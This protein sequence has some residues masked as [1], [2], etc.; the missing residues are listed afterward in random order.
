MD[1]SEFSEKQKTLIHWW[2]RDGTSSCDG[3]IADGAIRSG[4]TISMICGFLLWSQSMFHDR[5]FIIAGVTIT[6]VTRNVVLPMFEILNDWRWPFSQNKQLG[7]VKIGSNYYWVLSGGSDYAQDRMQGMTAAGAFADE[8]ALMSKKFL[9]QMIGRCSVEGSKVWFNCNPEN[10]TAFFKTD[11]IDVRDDKNLLYV[12]FLMDDNPSLSEETKARY[13]RMFHGVFRERYILGLWTKA[14]GLIYPEYEASFEEP[15][16]YTATQWAISCDYGTQNPFCALKWCKDKLGIW[17][18]VDEYYY[19][20]RAEGHQ[21]TDEDYANEMETFC[22]G[23]ESPDFIVDPSATSFIVMLRRRKKFRVL[24]ADNAVLDGIR[25][26][27]VCMQRGYVKLSEK[28]TNLK[29]E[30][31]GYSW[32]EKAN[33]DRPIKENDHACDALRYFVRTKRVYMQTKAYRSPFS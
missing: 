1:V 9:N 30:L 28:C 22:E 15:A 3:V 2:E 21:K 18:C 26:T 20:G 32:D 23:L 17:H 5:N 27:A 12:H 6:A 31:A 10:P 4:K 7:Y 33:S 13:S 24:K 19:S 11:F 16:R 29:Q 8:A 14:E 25:D